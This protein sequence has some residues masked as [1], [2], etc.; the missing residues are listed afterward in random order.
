M[1]AREKTKRPKNETERP[2]L[3]TIARLS[4]LAVPTVSRALS[5]APDIGDSTKERVK[6]IADE[7][8]YRRDRTA[9]RLRTGKTNVVALVI[10]ANTDVMNHTARLIS[11]IA[12][13]LRGTSYH[14]I[15]TPYFEDQTPL[16]PIK[17]IV[18]TGSADGVIINRIQPDDP[19]V[20]YLKEHNFPYVLHGRTANCEN[21]PY[22]DFDNREFAK[23]CIDALNDRGRKNI[24]L[25]AP[26][27][28]QSYALEMIA[29]AEDAMK[30]LGVKV[31]TLTGATSDSESE[32]VT[33]AVKDAFEVDPEIDA[34][35]AASPPAA[36]AATLAIESLG[37]D[38]GD[39]VDIVSKEAI[40]FLKAFRSKMLVVHEDV[41]E[42]GSFLSRALMRAIDQPDEE[43]MQ[44][45]AR[46]EP[47]NRS[48]E[49]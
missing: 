1:A 47:L 45:L 36:I 19:R 9:L 34:I 5:N 18:E 2:T 6:R 20:A 4:G 17:Y 40:P 26:L 8:G 21:D 10:G 3:K 43:P 7:I 22:F 23:V 38:V 29:G 15:V 49:N 37:H 24:L 44:H 28:D 16:D 13:E 39:S 32:A 33:E 25:I 41:S 30:K 42:A 12:L 14:M 27:Q 48:Y 31:T 46:P 11:S 35:I